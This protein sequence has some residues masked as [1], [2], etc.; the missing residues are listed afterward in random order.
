M[1]AQDI[2]NS[3]VNK[4]DANI[5][6]PIP[7]E[8]PSIIEP[9]P[10]PMPYNP[11]DQP[12]ESSINQ[13]NIDPQPQAQAQPHSVLPDFPSLDM[14]NGVLPNPNPAQPQP[15]SQQKPI[16]PFYGN[17]AVEPQPNPNVVPGSIP[18]DQ[19]QDSKEPQPLIRT[20]VPPAPFL[21]PYHARSP[22]DVKCQAL[23]L[24]LV[25]SSIIT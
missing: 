10:E 14:M 24:V 4:P 17:H 5:K 7:T 11:D 25:I 16:N 2:I 13:L 6:V 23:V 21:Q 12:P 22:L 1:D 19:E 9:P 18:E 3:I 20:N 15:H 8:P